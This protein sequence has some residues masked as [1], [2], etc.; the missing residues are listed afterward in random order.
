MSVCVC[1]WVGVS[2]HVSTQM[3]WGQDLAPAKETSVYKVQ[4]Q[5]NREDPS[6]VPRPLL[7]LFRFL[8]FRHLGR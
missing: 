5:N 2:V 3:H 6:G 4:I 8:F 1:G 7:A